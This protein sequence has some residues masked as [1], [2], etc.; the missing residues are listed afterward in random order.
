MLAPFKFF[1]TP[2][3]KPEL[4]EPKGGQPGLKALGSKFCL[5]RPT[6]DEKIARKVAKLLPKGNLYGASSLHKG[7]LLNPLRRHR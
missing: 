2:M 6:L 3:I 7:L 5:P 4:V 1:H